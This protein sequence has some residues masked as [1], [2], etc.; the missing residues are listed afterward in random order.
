MLSNINIIS[1]QSH[2]AIFGTF[3]K[4]V[5]ITLHNVQHMKA[6]KHNGTWDSVPE[7]PFEILSIFQ[8]LFLFSDISYGQGFS[9]VCDPHFGS[10]GHF[11]HTAPGMSPEM[12]RP[13]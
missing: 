2:K 4:A 10:T 5:K 11:D 7:T 8:K 12:L 13:L 9:S 6:N 3:F 1:K